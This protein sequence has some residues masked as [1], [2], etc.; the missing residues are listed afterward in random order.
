MAL[1]G[2]LA[3]VKA[4]ST[5]IAFTDEATTTSDNISYTI[6]NATKLFW[7]LETP[8]IVKDGGVVTIENY[9][10]SRLTGKV[11]FD[12]VNATRDITVSGKYVALTTVAQA[13][14]FSF[15]ASTDVLDATPFQE[16]F[17]KFESS[18]ITATAELGKFFEIDDI[19]VDMLLDGSTKILEYYPNDDLDPIRFFGVA[20][21]VNIEAPQ[22]GLLD[23]TIS[24]N[25]TTEIEV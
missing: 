3:L 20:N 9:T 22:A 15:A 17:R 14:S 7:D 6:T 24:F 12:V 8:V 4:S 25:I 19:F 2:Y 1:R 18:N 21:N 13:K 23:E 10:L 5:P 16:L 11:L